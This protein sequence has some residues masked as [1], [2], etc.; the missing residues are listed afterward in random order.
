MKSTGLDK[1]AGALGAHAIDEVDPA[2]QRREPKG[3]AR[4]R[5]SPTPGIRPSTAVLIGLSLTLPIALGG[6]ALTPHGTRDE[7]ARLEAASKPFETPIEARN[8]P[9]LPAHASW[10]DVLH[11]AFLANGDL[12]AAY[13][14]W[15]AA[16]IE[17][18]KASA[19]PNSNATFTYG[20]MFSP[21]NMTAWDRT[22][23]ATGFAPS[24]MLQLPIKSAAAGKVALE[25]AREAGE[26]FRAAK[27]DLQKKVLDAYLDLAL[28]EEKVRI[29]RDVVHLLDLASASA[30]ARA[31]VGESVPDAL[32]AKT[33]QELAK[34][35]L[36]NLEADIRSAKTQLNGFL[37]RDA[38]AP[39]SL[40][41]HLPAPRP[42]I[43]SDARLIAV[44]V[45][46]NP[47]L[48]ALA[49]QV[50]GRKDAI[51]L[52]SLAYLPD[53]SPSFSLT[54]SISRSLGA[55]AMLPTTLPQIRAT[56][57]NAAAMERSSEAL[58]RQTGKDRAASFVASLY[59]M[60]NAERQ[61]AFYRRT[62]VPLVRETLA[63]SQQ[64]YAAGQ[65]PFVDLID[66]IRTYDAIELLVA[67]A[68]IAREKR[69]AVIEAL[70]GVDVETLG[71][72]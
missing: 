31:Q 53:I 72:P 19:W 36:R 58:L 38:Q 13:F 62:V 60:R 39:L 48:A 17:I 44:A 20:Y 52:A 30:A 33:E 57:D 1:I 46:R 56:I 40:P 64:A 63:S 27:F 10:R 15:K 66:S 43:A 11:R 34:N 18:E 21:A 50:V 65:S 14:K 55:M 70:A 16:V 2:R 71:K 69:L 61:V 22:T 37:A 67:E 47:E 28:A 24:T 42:V 54:G 12:E 5:K 8:P 49:R 68:R 25:V 9:K 45:D 26:E 23:L 41:P 3:R 4:A 32:K 29:Q 59:L 51:D 6:C 35:N 7:Q